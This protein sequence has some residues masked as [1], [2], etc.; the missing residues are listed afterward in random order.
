MRS[1]K[2]QSN[3]RSH[4]HSMCTTLVY[5]HLLTCFILKLVSLRW[6]FSLSLYFLCSMHV[7]VCVCAEKGTA[8]EIIFCMYSIPNFSIFNQIYRMK[9]QSIT[10]FVFISFDLR[11]FF[12][13]IFLARLT[14]FNDIEVLRTQ[15]HDTTQAAMNL[16][17]SARVREMSGKKESKTAIKLEREERKKDRQHLINSYSINTKITRYTHNN[18]THGSCSENY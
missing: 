9:F 16:N 7:C 6:F 2:R 12:V 1:S 8:T 10:F 3:N 14:F 17:E 13:R 5:T 11:S 4:T 15:R 18:F